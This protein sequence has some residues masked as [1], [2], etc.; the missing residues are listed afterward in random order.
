MLPARTTPLCG[1]ALIDGRGAL[2]TPYCAVRLGLPANEFTPLSE[3]LPTYNANLQPFRLDF[4][5]LTRLAVLNGM[6]V[7][8]GD[9]IVGL[10]ALY[11]IK[12]RWPHLRIHLYRSRQCSANLEQIYALAGFFIDEIRYLPTPVSVLQDEPCL[13]DLADFAFRPAFDK[14]PMLDFFLDSLGLSPDEV[15]PALKYPAWLADPR[16]ARGALPAGLSQKG[17]IL[18]APVASE[19]LRNIPPAVSQQIVARLWALHGLPIVGLVQAID[20]PHYTCLA[21]PLPRLADY[22]ALV[23]GAARVVSTDT[24]ALHVAA[25]LAVPTLGFFV[26]IDP[27]LRVAHYPAHCAVRVSTD[28]RLM[29]RHWHDDALQLAIAEAAWLDFAA[30]PEL[31]ARLAFSSA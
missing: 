17:Y 6:G 2:F 9:S 3:V 12:Q 5:K 31:D 10:Q 14:L 8:L 19:P 26:S 7:A 13:V 30:R 4:A 20:H 18:F 23:G 29:G 15:S 28:A 25:G 11:L 24:S 21:T 27:A 22:I 1:Q 16:R